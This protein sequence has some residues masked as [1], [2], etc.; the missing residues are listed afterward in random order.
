MLFALKTKASEIRSRIIEGINNSNPKKGRAAAE[1]VTPKTEVIRGNNPAMHPGQIPE[2]NP[3]NEPARVSP[4]EL[5][6]AAE[7]VTSL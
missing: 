3:P 5:L 4:V 7:A 6:A 2:S 1:S